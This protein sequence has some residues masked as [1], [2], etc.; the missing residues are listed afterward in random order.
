MVYGYQKAVHM[1]NGNGL[2]CCQAWLHRLAER[3]GLRQLARVHAASLE[4]NTNESTKKTLHYYID[5]SALNGA[6]EVDFTETIGVKCVQG[7]WSQVCLLVLGGL[8]CPPAPWGTAATCQR[9]EYPVGDP[10]QVR[11]MHAQCPTAMFH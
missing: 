4:A 11:V 3:V 7:G 5:V 9:S 6:V 8:H 10:R 1:V 2:D